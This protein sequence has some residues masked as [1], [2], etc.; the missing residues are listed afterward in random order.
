MNNRDIL[1]HY[2]HL[3]CVL[4]ILEIKYPPWKIEKDCPLN[5]REK[6]ATIL[7]V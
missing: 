6:H 1:T 5:N 3:A 2:V 7:L 4:V